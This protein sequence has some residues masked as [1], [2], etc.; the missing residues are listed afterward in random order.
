LRPCEFF[1]GGAADCYGLSGGDTV[2]E[3]ADMAFA[4]AAKA[5]DGDVDLGVLF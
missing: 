5:G 4:H 3:S 1:G 2:Q